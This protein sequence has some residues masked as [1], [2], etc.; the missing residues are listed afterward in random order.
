VRVQDRDQTLGHPPGQVIKPGDAKA[1]MHEGMPIYKNPFEKGNLY[2]KFT[3]TFPE[4]HFQSEDTL[5]LLES[6]LPPRPPF[7]MP[8]GEHVEEVD[9]SE[10][11]PD[12]GSNTRQDEAYNSDDEGGMPHGAFIPCAH[13]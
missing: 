2:V 12:S 10:Y 11:S 8:V 9:L 7:V 1:V 5:R 13:Q 3:V 4:N 6:C